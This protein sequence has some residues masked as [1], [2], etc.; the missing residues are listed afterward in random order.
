MRIRHW[1]FDF[2]GTLIDSAPAILEAFAAALAETG[3]SPQ[4]AL[5]DRL[6]GPPLAE[7]LARISGSD[8]PALIQLLTERFKAHYD[9]D[10]VANTHAYAGVEQ[11]LQRLS[12]DGLVLHIA[13]NK[14]FSATQAILDHLGWK[15]YFSTVYALDMVAPRLPGK[16][17]LLQK[18]LAELALPANS[19]RYIG[20]KTED[21]AAASAN[22]LRFHYAAWGYGDLTTDTLPTEWHWLAQPLDL[23]AEELPS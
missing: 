17:A 2:D 21:G 1:I 9:R 20:D 18:Q 14:R 6:I 23:L 15:H 19:A 8:D 10:G 7:T 16:A 12:A 22:G 13:T 5:D 3:L 11:L 4:V